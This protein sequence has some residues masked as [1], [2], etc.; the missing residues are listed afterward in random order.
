MP[1]KPPQRP[2]TVKKVLHAG[3]GPLPEFRTD[4]KAIFDYE[5]L[6]PLVDLD[7]EG[8]PEDRTLYKSIDS[9][10]RKWPDGYGKPLELVFG[11]KFQLPIFETCL[12]TMLVDEV[13]QFD[14]GMLDMLPYPMVSKKLRDISRS[15]VDPHHHADHHHE[16]HCAAMG[17]IKL[18]YEELDD[19]LKNPR[20]LRVIMHLL[21]V[22]QPEE[23]NADSW[24]MSGEQKLDSLETLRED[25]NELF[26]KGD[27]ENASTK[28][29]E[30]LGRLDTLLLKEKPGDPEWVELDKKN[31]SLYLNLSQCFLNMSRWHDAM[32]T[33]SEVLKRD[34]TNEKALFRRAKAHIGRWELDEAERDLLELKKAHPS[35]ENLVQTQLAII[36]AKRKEKDRTDKATYKAMFAA[37]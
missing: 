25:G 14:I 4:T 12:Q 10:Q 7:K 34:A 16:H 15:D 32:E 6:L 24:Q 36:D 11:K 23:Y 20:P 19:L 18:D 5:V 17:P 1:S 2:R 3:K 37:K 35:S 9:T 29:R 27:F 13:S 30:A 28:Y 22:L 21:K 8:F 31:I 33:A 26:K